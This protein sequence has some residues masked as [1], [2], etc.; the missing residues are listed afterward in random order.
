MLFGAGWGLVGYCPGPALA[1]I[2]LGN[3]TTLLYVAAM[4]AGMVGFALW[5]SRVARR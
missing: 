5:P 4:I 3:P 2:A 1:S